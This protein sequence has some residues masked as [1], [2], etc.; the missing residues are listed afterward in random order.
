MKYLFVA[1]G[2]GHIEFSCSGLIHD[3]AKSKDDVH[4]IVMN[5]D[6]NENLTQ[7]ETFVK[8]GVK[9]ENIELGNFWY[10]NDKG[11][12][13]TF[14]ISRLTEQ[15]WDAVFCRTHLTGRE[16]DLIIW[17]E[18]IKE[19]SD[20]CSIMMFDGVMP[21][22]KMLDHSKNNFIVPITQEATD[23]K[24]EIL[25][26]GLAERFEVYSIQRIIFRV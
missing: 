12:Y 19:S 1:D 18:I 2:T 20:D 14:L 22:D 10:E 7:I 8:L 24:S 16:E 5:V 11:F 21:M 4:I 15:K 26:L 17:R 9:D 23:V 13:K 6:P 25:Q 3:L